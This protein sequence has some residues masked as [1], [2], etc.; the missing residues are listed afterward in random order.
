MRDAGGEQGAID[1]ARVVA[2]CGV[3]LECGEVLCGD[4]QVAAWVAR[5]TGE[6]RAVMRR[7]VW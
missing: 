4:E 5:G 1:W 2:V 3:V 7:R 6:E